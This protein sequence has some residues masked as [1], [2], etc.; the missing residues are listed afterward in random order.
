MEVTTVTV[1]RKRS[2]QPEQYGNAA[3]ELTVVA[4]V[5]AGE[6]WDVVAKSLLVSTRALVY[7]NLGLKLPASAGGATTDT[8]ADTTEVKV[9]TKTTDKSK[10]E[11]KKRG[12]GRP[13]KDTSDLPGVVDESDDDKTDADTPSGDENV[14]AED[15][16]PQPMTQDELQKHIIGWI[17]SKN[18]GGK[19]IVIGDARAIMS[20]IAKVIQSK[21][22]PDDKVQE[23]YDTIKGV[24][25]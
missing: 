11:T 6:D 4:I 24:V 13:R 10:S 14:E 19:G 17:K 16:T 22:V 7:E 18:K 2:K 20:D 9:E 1:T 23:V 12:P 8:P 21:E 15:T 5:D 25:A 3:A